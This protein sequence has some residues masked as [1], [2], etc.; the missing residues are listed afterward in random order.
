MTAQNLS[1]IIAFLGQSTLSFKR[2]SLLL[3]YYIVR[4]TNEILSPT[5]IALYMYMLGPDLNV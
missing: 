5:K 4:A 1:W 2:L 3:K